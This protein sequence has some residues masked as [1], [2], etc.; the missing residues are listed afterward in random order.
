M[1]VA[2]STHVAVY[3]ITP[4]RIRNEANFL[5]I[6][7]KA[8]NVGILPSKNIDITMILERN[9][10]KRKAL[11]AIFPQQAFAISY[12]VYREGAIFFRE[13]VSKSKKNI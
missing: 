8:S 7:V 1:S 4:Q 11:C 12:L 5:F 9:L 6:A 2:L 10:K 13:I 3:K